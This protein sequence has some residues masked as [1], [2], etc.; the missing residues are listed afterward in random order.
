MGLVK[1]FALVVVAAGAGSLLA[2]TA[3]PKVM[4]LTK[5]NVKHTGTV[6][7]GLTAGGTV[8]IYAVL[9]SAI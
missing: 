2:A 4:E 1:T 8:L 5:L 7:T 9:A 6:N 3:T